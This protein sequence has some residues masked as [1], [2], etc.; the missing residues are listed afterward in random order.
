MLRYMLAMLFGLAGLV[1]LP[2]L[3][4]ALTERMSSTD[5]SVMLTPEQ[6]RNFRAWMLRIMQEQIRQGPSPRWVQRDCVSLVRYSVAESLRGH[7]TRWLR[8]NGFS[9]Q[10]LPEELHLSAEQEELRHVWRRTDGSKGA[11]VSAIGMVQENSR[12]VAKDFNLA[13]PGDLLFFDQGDEQHLMVWMNGMVIYHTGTVTAQDN[14]LRS[15]PV[16]QLLRWKDTRWRPTQDN[17]NFVGIYRLA[18]LPR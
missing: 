6:S 7:D 1:V 14:G 5:D 3:S 4:F 10:Q 9:A 12:Y 11:Y 2:Q 13:Q 8:A 18:F 17:P 15:I 16:S